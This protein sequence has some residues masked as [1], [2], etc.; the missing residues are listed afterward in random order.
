MLLF[1]GRCSVRGC[2]FAMV[3]PAFWLRL[4]RRRSGHLGMKLSEARNIQCTH[5]L[6]QVLYGRTVTSYGIGRAL[7]ANGDVCTAQLKIRMPAGAHFDAS[8]L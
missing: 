7:G 8:V 6:L 3:R 2:L 4:Q 5:N 1:Y